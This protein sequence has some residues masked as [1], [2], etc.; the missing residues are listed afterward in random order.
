MRSVDVAVVGAGPA[1]I[2]AA[3]A[4][5]S[6]G[7]E[8][9]LLDENP[10]VGG[11]LRWRVSL[12]LDQT[13]GLNV[14]P[15]SGPVIA[16]QLASKLDSIANLTVETGTV[17]W[18]LFDDNVLGISSEISADELQARSIVLATGSTDIALPFPG[19][20]LPGV[21]TARAA[22]IFMHIHRVLPGRTWVILGDT[23]E[24]DEIVADLDRAGVEVTA[25]CA[26]VGQ[27]RASGTNRLSHIE[28]GD[29]VYEADS[30]A[31]ALGRQPDAELAFH[32]RAEGAFVSELG[33]YSVNRDEYGQTSEAG[34]YITGDAAGIATLP[35][36]VT[37]GHLVGLAAAGA[38]ETDKKN[39]REAFAAVATEGR[40]RAITGLRL[41]P[42][43]T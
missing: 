29:N 7:A 22:Q 31:I 1:G 42:A 38:S 11:Q 17:A 33:G 9:I 41:A 34:V 15:G 19:W 40:N 12:T 20:T 4:A 13:G 32:A 23:S 6:S 36:L 43:S 26:D 35:E 14:S 5:A 10:S 30:L 8:T 37:E 16:S 39:A 3:L 25:R 24:A 28:I 2:S 27:I 21:M 18:G